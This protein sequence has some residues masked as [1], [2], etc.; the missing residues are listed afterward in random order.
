MISTESPPNQTNLSLF[1]LLI[2]YINTFLLTEAAQ[3]L[4]GMNPFYPQMPYY[5]NGMMPQIPIQ[6]PPYY[7]QYQPPMMPNYMMSPPPVMNP[8]FVNSGPGAAAIAAALNLPMPPSLDNSIIG[9]LGNSIQ[10]PLIPRDQSIPIGLLSTN[11]PKPKSPQIGSIAA[12]NSPISNKPIETAPV[13]V[14]YS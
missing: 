9:Q 4:P 2:M 3:M 5:P 11:I 7:P 1:L 8:S 6:Y 10:L 12:S 13:P 14:L